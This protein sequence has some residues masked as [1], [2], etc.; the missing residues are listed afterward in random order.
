[1]AIRDP[2]PFM[3]AYLGQPYA[4]GFRCWAVNKSN[5][6]AKRGQYKSFANSI[7]CEGP[8]NGTKI[9]MDCIGAICGACSV[10]KPGDVMGY[11]K[12]GMSYYPAKNGKKGNAFMDAVSAEG[13]RLSWGA[14][15]ITGKNVPEPTAEKPGVA[16]FIKAQTGKPGHIGMYMGNGI[17]HEAT[18]PRV[19][20][21]KL[22]ARRTTKDRTSQWTHW[23][24]VPASW[25]S[26]P[27]EYWGQPSTSAPEK[28][29]QAPAA[30]PVSTLTLSDLKPG[31]LVRIKTYG[32]PYYP[33]GTVIPDAAW[34]RGKGMTVNGLGEKGGVPCARL[35]EITSWCAIN[36]L[37]K[38]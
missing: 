20:E 22:Y 10:E 38:V 3:R 1:M 18:P 16:V 29:V 11:T 4:Y 27:C 23:A 5:V 13:A 12:T 25:L 24:Y 7:P 36:N 28:P 19:Q 35:A 2:R 34:L 8:I 15:P 21:T 33:G 6:D 26:W 17:V 30:P 32:V 14:K 37:E 31:E 9:G